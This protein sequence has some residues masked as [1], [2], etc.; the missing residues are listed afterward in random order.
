MTIKQ[1]GFYEN[2]GLLIK[3]WDFGASVPT[4]MEITASKKLELRVKQ[5]NTLRPLEN[6]TIKV[7]GMSLPQT[8]TSGSDGSARV[9]ISPIAM[10]YECTVADHTKKTGT[11]TP[12]LSADYIDIIMGYAAMTFSLILTANNPYSKAAESCPV[13]VTSAWGGTSSQAYSFSGTTN[14]SGQLISQG[15]GNFNIPPGN[16][17]ITYGGGNSNFNSKTEN[18]YL[19]T[20]KTHSAVLTRRTK[21]VTFTV[22]EIIPS[23]S[24]TASNPVKTGLVLACYYNDNSTSSGANVTTNASGQF[25]KTVYAGIAERFQVQPVGFYS[26]N[27]AVATINY[28]EANTKRPCIYMFKEN[29]SICD[30]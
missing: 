24:T 20:D 2:E 27:G 9:Y 6:A 30:F 8:V 21:S 1:K 12:P 23:I 11:F 25:T 15:N 18:I 10:S 19:P 14:A 29:S 16:Y 4:L 3:N 28:R 5:Q 7:S 26:G 17:T 22:K 13:T